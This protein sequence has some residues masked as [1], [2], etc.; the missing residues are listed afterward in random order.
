MAT[1]RR[2][3]DEGGGFVERLAGRGEEAVGRLVDELTRNPRVTDAL[4]KA[5]S[6]K[7]KVDAGARRTL[8]QVGLAAADEL[9]DLRKQIERLERRL[10]KLEGASSARS[11]PA[12]GSTAKRSQ[13]KKKPTARKRTTT[14]VK[15][16]AK[17]AA[18][19]PAGRSLGGGPGRGS[20]AGG[21]SAAA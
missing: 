3:P 21:G 12:S 4:G 14:T 13:T 5:M 17:K 15:Q 18:S 11:R 10:A 20:G 1:Q 6:A 8:S 9:K 7:G 19:P 16:D 2:K